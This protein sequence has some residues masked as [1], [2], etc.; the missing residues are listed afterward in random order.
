MTGLIY[1]TEEVGTVKKL[2]IL[3]GTFDPI[4]NGHLY[5]ARAAYE[6][7]GL[8]KV[9]LIPA[10]IA[11][12]KVGLDC[13]PAKDRYLMTMF[14]ISD[15]P[16]FEACD[17]ELRREG[18]SY[19]YDTIKSLQEQYPEYELFFIIGGDT[20]EQ[21]PT[22]YKIEELLKM[23]TFVAVG[24]PGYA[25]VID[26]AAQKLG[27]VVYEKVK[28]LDTEE[29]SVSSTEIRRRIRNRRNLIGLVP[30]AV[31]EYIYLNGLYHANTIT[32]VM[33]DDGTFDLDD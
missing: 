3:G 32:Q 22:W 27:S 17:I 28:M 29:F 33:K 6:V 25:D 2:G 18:V 5:L 12:H 14:A 20:V 31:Q 23:V 13:A 9:L 10:R 11:P 19:T 7:L 21:L 4:H 30:E 26:K 16:N 15:E 8:D 24:R 1:L